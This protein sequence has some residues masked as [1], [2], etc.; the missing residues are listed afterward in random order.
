ML[1]WDIYFHF[2]KILW[3]NFRKCKNKPR[4]EIKLV[5]FLFIFVLEILSNLFSLIRILYPLFSFLLKFFLAS[6]YIFHLVFAYHFVFSCFSLSLFSPPLSHDQ[7][8]FYSSLA[9]FGDISCSIVMINS[10][11]RHSLFLLA[12]RAW[13]FFNQYS[14]IPCFTSS[15]LL[16]LIQILSTLYLP[17]PL[18]SFDAISLFIILFIQDLLMSIC[19]QCHFLVS[20]SQEGECEII[21]D[22]S[23]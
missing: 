19:R 9:N 14:F 22:L 2:S 17:K 7:I 6:F 3:A 10:F 21:G 1:T 4:A 5:S 20:N 16:I 15:R 12:F 11:V 8:D 18:S 13:Y 23:D